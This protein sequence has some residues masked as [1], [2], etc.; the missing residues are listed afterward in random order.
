MAEKN[1]RTEQRIAHQVDCTDRYIH[2]AAEEVW[3]MAQ[4][5]EDALGKA[6]TAKEEKA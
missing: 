5:L 4:G 1:E 2:A 3:E 6:P